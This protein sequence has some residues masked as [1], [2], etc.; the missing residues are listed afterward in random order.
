MDLSTR[1]SR[2][3]FV[4]LLRYTKRQR[5]AAKQ[6]WAVIRTG[7]SF[8]VPASLSTDD[9]TMKAVQ[10]LCNQHPEVATAER[11]PNGTMGSPIILQSRGIVVGL[12]KTMQ[13]GPAAAQVLEAYGYTPDASGTLTELLAAH[14]Q[15]ITARSGLTPKEAVRQAQ[16]ESMERNK[17][18]LPEQVEERAKQDGVVVASPVSQ[19]S[20]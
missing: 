14:E 10:C 11:S 7:V 16:Q 19:E 17:I 1:L 12:R 2:L 3:P 9:D 4:D 20:K 18:V 13:I 6:M 8:E 15:F 5:E